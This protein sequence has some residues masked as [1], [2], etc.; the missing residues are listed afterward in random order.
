MYCSESSSHSFTGLCSG[1]SKVWKCWIFVLTV[2]VVFVVFVVV[3]VI[4]EYHM[5][6]GGHRERIGAELYKRRRGLDNIPI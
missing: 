4:A 2:V 3:L 5:R 1:D 6:A